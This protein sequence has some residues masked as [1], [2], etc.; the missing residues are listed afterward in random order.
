VVH[1]PRQALAQ[2]RSKSSNVIHERVDRTME[3]IVAPLNGRSSIN[4]ENRRPSFL[5]SAHCMHDFGGRFGMRIDYGNCS[6]A[7]TS[8]AAVARTP[9][10]LALSQDGVRDRIARA[11]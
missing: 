10:A 4:D 7:R 9:P 11:A 1:I 3:I 8:I 5:S 6:V 2:V